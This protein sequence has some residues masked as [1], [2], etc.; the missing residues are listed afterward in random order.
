VSGNLCIDKKPAAIN[1]ILGRGKIVLADVTV[2]RE[3]LEEKMHATPEAVAETCFRKCS[4]GSS[5]AAS[6]G[7]NAH[8]ANMI[9]ALY[10]ATGQ[11][12]AQ[13]VEGSMV[14]TTC[15]VVDGGLYVS[16]RLPC[17][18]VGT[19]GGGTRLPCQSEA[20]SMIGCLGD[21][22]SLKLAEI[23]GAVVLAGEL[24]TLSAQAA[25][26]LGQAHSRLG[27]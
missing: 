8:A 22:K 11:D 17:V 26:H 19:V 14:T 1:S 20:L 9:A 4:I 27:R 18:E 25:G 15:E 21:G 23:V 3:M 16:V 24:S 10:I 12:P 7:S 2:P 13:V 6:L 5:L